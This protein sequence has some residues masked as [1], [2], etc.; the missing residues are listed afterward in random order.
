MVNTNQRNIGSVIC[1]KNYVQCG[2]N[3]NVRSCASTGFRAG[4]Q[5]IRISCNCSALSGLWPL[6]RKL[7]M[8]IV[9]APIVDPICCRLETA[10]VERSSTARASRREDC[11]QLRIPCR[12]ASSTCGRDRIW[13][14]RNRPGRQR[15]PT[16]YASLSRVTVADLDQAAAQFPARACRIQT[17]FYRMGRAEVSAEL[18][19]APGKFI[20][21]CGSAVVRVSGKNTKGSCSFTHWPVLFK[22]QRLPSINMFRPIHNRALSSGICGNARPL[23]VS[24]R[25]GR[26][27]RL[28]LHAG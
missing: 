2:E 22:A 5:N 1:R 19:R 4:W 17:E 16:P 12:S 10:T 27:P 18:R 24:R 14:S 21:T 25:A 8:P 9:K 11:Q 20:R 3:L 15:Q 28:I 26:S 7:E 23:C 6:N 13:A